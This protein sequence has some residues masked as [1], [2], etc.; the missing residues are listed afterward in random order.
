MWSRWAKPDNAGFWASLLIVLALNKSTLR[1]EP[2]SLEHTIQVPNRQF[3]A[4]IRCEI[5]EVQKNGLHCIIYNK[6]VAINVAVANR[7]AQNRTSC[8]NSP[9][10]HWSVPLCYHM[11]LSPLTNCIDGLKPWNKIACTSAYPYRI[12]CATDGQHCLKNGMF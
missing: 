4:G 6:A 5:C 2:F 8:A 12:H 7:L 11:D 1:R 3:E 9:R 10:G